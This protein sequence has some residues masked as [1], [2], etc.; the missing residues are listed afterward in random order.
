MKTFPFRTPHAIALLLAALVASSPLLLSAAETKPPPAAKPALDLKIDRNAINREGADRVSY[1][2]VIKKTAASVVYVYSTKTVHGRDLAPLLED[3]RLR[4]YF[5]IADGDH[6]KV[7][8]MVQHGL[9]SGIVVTSDGYLLT[10]NHIVEGADDVKIAIGESN[11]R[12]DAKVVGTDSL[13]DVAL[14]KIDANGLTPAILGDSE[15]LQVG[16]VV[17]AIG[18]PFGIGQSVSRGIVSALGRGNLGIEPVEDFIQTDAA[19]NPGNS[20]GALIDSSGR[21]VG[22]NT[23]IVAGENGYS[24]VGFAIPVNLA[25]RIADQIVTTGRVERG[26]LGV[27]PQSLTPELAEEFKAD[28]GAL[29]AQV[30]PGSPAAK[31]GLKPGDVVTKVNDA[32]IR[33]EGQLLLTIS[34]LAPSTSV[35]IEYLRGGKMQT[36]RATLERRPD[37]KIARERQAR[38]EKLSPTG[39]EPERNALDGV[40][41]T[42][43]TP[44]LRERLELPGDL[45][46]AVI[47]EIDPTSASAREGLRAG[48]VILELDH[49]PVSNARQA[50]DLSKQLS[51]QKVLARVWREGQTRFV[52]I[53]KPNG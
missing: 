3:P 11:K 46:G 24:G 2:P 22:L 25:R 40:G 1:A 38:P 18:N 9:G 49:K 48:D 47:T 44:E 39:R 10:N 19:I 15:Q 42:D 6:L 31:A 33:D 36:A 8:D 14:L 16:D 5:G 20:G 50:V 53:Q 43:L 13:T 32:A 34:S 27:E 51:G 7:P 45:K 52:M 29:L 23:A 35:T 30:T 37:E 41:V 17:L 12:Y 21:V 28:R 4:R 26:Y